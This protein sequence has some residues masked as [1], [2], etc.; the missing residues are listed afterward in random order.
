MLYFRQLQIYLDEQQDIKT[1]KCECPRGAFK[2]S[3]AATF[4]IHGIYH[5]RRT[6]M[7]CHWKKRKSN[8]SLSNQAVSEL[9]PL[10]C[11]GHRLALIAP[12]SMKI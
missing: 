10:L 4:F 11:R 6:E 8:P 3:H 7:E 12:H 1:I 2:C 5:L 9:F